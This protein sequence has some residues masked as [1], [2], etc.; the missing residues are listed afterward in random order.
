MSE[1]QRYP[2]A[3]HMDARTLSD[4][5]PWQ[6]ALKGAAQGARA[7]NVRITA[8]VT[9]AQ[10]AALSGRSDPA[11]VLGYDMMY[12][13]Q[14]CLY[15][16]AV[17]ASRVHNVAAAWNEQ[18]GERWEPIPVAELGTDALLA[19]LRACSAAANAEWDTDY[20]FV[21]DD[22]VDEH[23]ANWHLFMRPQT[24]VVTE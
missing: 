11:P 19:M 20:G 9:S 21:D 16:P 2:V 4:D 10:L 5:I 12:F 3:I 8:D 15:G 22:Y 18:T 7:L 6:A 24:D 17:A 23:R 1:E 13:D 14:E